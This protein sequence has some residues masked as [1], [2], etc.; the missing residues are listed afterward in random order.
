MM[1]SLRGVL[2]NPCAI[3]FVETN[4]KMRTILQSLLIIAVAFVYVAGPCVTVEMEHSHEVCQGHGHQHSGDDHDHPHHPH[5]E[6][7]PSSSDD[8]KNGGPD[9][10][11]HSHSHIVS[12]GA[13]T[14]FTPASFKGFMAN[15]IENCHPVAVS[16]FFPDKPC[17][18]LIKP[19][20]LG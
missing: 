3:T 1:T 12:L 19:P 5:D 7:S 11:S 16:E 18:P 2:P 14:P 4:C 13:D 10:D 6:D 8:Q 17:F 20:R 9:G 15:R